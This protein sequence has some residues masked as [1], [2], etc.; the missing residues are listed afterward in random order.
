MIQTVDNWLDESLVFLS[1]QLS[2]YLSILSI[3]PSIYISVY[4]SI[5]LS[6]CLFIHPSI[7]LSIHP[8]ISQSIQPS[9][10]LPIHWPIHACMHASIN[11]Y[12]LSHP[13]IHSLIFSSIHPFIHPSYLQCFID[14]LLVAVLAWYSPLGTLI[15]HVMVDEAS[16]QL[17]PTLVLTEDNL[18]LALPHM[19]LAWEISTKTITFH[20][21]KRTCGKII[22]YSHMPLLLTYFISWEPEGH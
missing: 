11:L 3:Y 13:F 2:I 8:S 14:E 22:P 7:Y 6:I 19:S 4:S 5:H 10:Y 17:G 20:L 18:L 15:Q 12:S 1:I 21:F 9:I 16:L